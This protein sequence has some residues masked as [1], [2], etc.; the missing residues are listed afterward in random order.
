MEHMIRACLIALR[1]G[2]H[3]GLSE[4]E[5]GVVYYSGLLAWVG[6]HTDAYE[7]AKWFGDDMTL[8]SDAHYAYDM[9]KV[10]PAI[11]FM[12]KHVGGPERNLVERARVGVA[13]MGDGRRALLALAENHYRATDELAGRLGLGEEIRESLRQTYER[14]D[15]KGAYGMRGEQVALASRL[16]NLA[17]VVEVFGRAGGVDAAVG[18]ARDRRGGQ[19]DPVLVDAF[20]E[21]APILLSEVDATPSWEAVIAAEPALAERIS[22]EE[23]DEA[24]EAVGEFAELKSPWTMGHARGVAELCGQAAREFGLPEGDAAALRRAGFVADLGRLGVPNTVWDKPGP[25]S[26]SE[27]E[28]VRL[29]PH[30]SERMLAFSPALAPLGALAVLHHERLDGSGYPRGLSGAAIS[31]AGRLLAAADVYHAMTQ[32][33]PHRP[34][35]TAGEAVRELRGEVKAG[36]LDGDAV[37]AVLRAAGHRVRRQREWPAGLTSR[38]V[39]VLRLVARGLSNKQIAALLVISPKT[40]GSHVE[41]IYRKIDASNRAQASLFAMKHGLMRDAPASDGP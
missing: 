1:L 4:A 18:V 33:R 26:Q 38:E 2:E 11:S 34:A 7:Q 25:L 30:L 24:L 8:K 19:F 41:H 20:C 29:H 32:M 35:L 40:A 36:R 15:G 14:W 23:L 3:L 21:Q 28:R 12:L 16:I 39:E 27:L 10:G 6:C 5:R 17:D 13:F 22:D 37:D 9:G 31:T